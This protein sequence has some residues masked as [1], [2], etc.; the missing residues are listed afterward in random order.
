MNYEQYKR[1]HYLLEIENTLER[2]LSRDIK[3]I[4]FQYIKKDDGII[5]ENDELICK[6]KLDGEYLKF[7]SY[8]KTIKEWS[9]AR[10]YIF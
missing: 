9:S 5:L 2:I 1:F 8:K 10:F 7:Y 4:I 3:N 6:I